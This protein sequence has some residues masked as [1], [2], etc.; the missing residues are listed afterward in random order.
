MEEIEV[1]VFDVFKVIFFCCCWFVENEDDGKIV[2]V[3]E[4]GEL[5]I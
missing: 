2:C 3:I 5:L 4:F 1:I